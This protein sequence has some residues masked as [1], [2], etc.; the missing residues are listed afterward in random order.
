MFWLFLASSFGVLFDTFRPCVMLTHH[1][2]RSGR[3]RGRRG[4]R[5]GPMSGFGVPFARF[6]LCL[7]PLSFVLA[8]CSAFPPFVSFGAGI[9][10]VR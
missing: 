6:L 8:R 2:S 10:T 4:P 7:A 9:L 5:P 1:P 3:M